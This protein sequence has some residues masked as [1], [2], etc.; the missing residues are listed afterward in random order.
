MARRSLNKTFHIKFAFQP[1]V[2]TEEYKITEPASKRPCCSCYFTNL[3]TLATFL[4][5]A[6]G[7]TAK[8]F[9]MGT[10]LRKDLFPSLPIATDSIKINRQGRNIRMY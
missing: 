9:L 5:F 4:L 10:R 6:D 7:T 8:L 2:N 3:E 1:V